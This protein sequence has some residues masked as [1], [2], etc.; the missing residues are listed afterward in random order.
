LA[1]TE[2][3]LAATAVGATVFGSFCEAEPVSEETGAATGLV[4]KVAAGLAPEVVGAGA[5]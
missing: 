1:G 3:A 4:P 2:V 5:G